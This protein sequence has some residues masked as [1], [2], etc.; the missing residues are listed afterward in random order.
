MLVYLKK[1]LINIQADYG[2]NPIIFAVIYFA[3][4][5]PFWFSIYK[6]MNGLKTKRLNQVSTYGIILALSIIAP[7][8]YVALFGHNLPFWFWIIAL[9]LIGFSVSSVIRRIRS[10]K[11]T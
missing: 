1:W 8:C 4:T 11:D 3:G 10:K 5:V 9:I 7:F 2:V 6:I